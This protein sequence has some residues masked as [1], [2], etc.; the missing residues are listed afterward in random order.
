MQCYVPGYRALSVVSFAA[1]NTEI[2]SIDV[3]DMELCSNDAKH[4]VF[5][6]TKIV[7]LWLRQSNNKSIAFSSVFTVAE[8]AESTR[9]RR[10][11]GT[12]VGV[13]S[14]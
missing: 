9:N 4:R 11:M 2:G 12:Y 3:V 5:S 6:S 10:N 1:V 13:R 14:I 7:L 8:A